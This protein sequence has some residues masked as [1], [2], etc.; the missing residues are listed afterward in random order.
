MISHITRL[1]L[2]K[3]SYD[4]PAIRRKYRELAEKETSILS[5]FTSKG[6]EI[7]AVIGAEASPTCGINIVGRWKDPERRGKFP[8][9]VEFVEGTGVFMEELR[10]EF[11]KRG[12][13][14]KWIGLPGKTLRE[15]DPQRYDKMKVIEELRNLIRGVSRPDPGIK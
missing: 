5:Q 12:I 3:D 2:P 11:E 6:Y 10:E 14:T 9:D 8:E 1:P 7:I 15:L 4:N 13:E